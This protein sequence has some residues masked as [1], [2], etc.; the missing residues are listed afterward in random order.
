MKTATPIA[1]IVSDTEFVELTNIERFNDRS[2]Y[3][4]RIRVGS[5]CFLCTGHPFYFNDLENFLAE[6]KTAH[7]KVSGVTELRDRYEDEFIKVKYSSNG[8]VLISGLLVEYGHLD[9][10]LQFAFETDQTFLPPF[11]ASV[12]KVVDELK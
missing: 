12:E 10:R 8:H 4:A 5:E 7:Q 11:I 3:C 1:L 2:G 6:L 9:R